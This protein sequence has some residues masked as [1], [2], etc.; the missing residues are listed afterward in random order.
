MNLL[1]TLLLF[2]NSC[3]IFT[4]IVSIINMVKIAHFVKTF[5]ISRLFSI[6][7]IESSAVRSFIISITCQKIMDVFEY[8]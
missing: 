6:F 7:D 5:E 2:E 4:L 3:L 1:I 8:I